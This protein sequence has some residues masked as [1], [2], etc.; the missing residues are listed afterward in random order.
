MNRQRI[1]AIA[2]AIALVAGVA[3][4]FFINRNRPS[5]PDDYIDDV[6][7]PVQIEYTPG[8][9]TPR[10]SS[11]YTQ[12]LVIYKGELYHGSG[13][14][15]DSRL[16]KVDIATGKPKSPVVKLGDEYF[17]EGIT[18]LNDTL[19]QLTWQEHKVFVYT[20]KDLKKI[21]EFPL[22]TDG[23][24]IT[25]DGKS[26]IVS[27]GNSRLYY[28]SPAGFTLEKKIDITN[29][30]ALQ[31]N[32]N[33][34]E[35]INGFIYANNYGFNT[36]FKIDPATGKVVGFLDLTELK[37]KADARYANAEV[38]NGIAY[39]AA[40]GKVYVTGKYWTELYEINFAK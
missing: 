8:N 39:D 5:K 20:A 36:I 24:G 6:L 12:G 18:I 25:T 1:A 31:P 9:A 7:R 34:L 23:W 27:D 28:Y 11:L 17:G 15:K 14:K 13:Q 40:T 19:Y 4:Y 33:E 38:L 30:G 32:L 10:D 3:G 21:K 2:I 16:M 26:L 22:Q 29:A 37:K 35:Y